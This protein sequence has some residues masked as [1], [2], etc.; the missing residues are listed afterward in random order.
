[1]SRRVSTE[2]TQ[3][4]AETSE[5]VRPPDTLS[6]R[7]TADALGSSTTKLRKLI[8]QG[9]LPEAEKVKT[10]EGRVWAVPV[11]AIPG[12]A[13]RLGMVVS[14][15]EAIDVREPETAV[16]T[17]QE[18]L[19]AAPEEIADAPDEIA[20]APELDIADAPQEIA[21]APE[22]I[23]VAVAA[24]QPERHGQT[25]S[26]AA[27]EAAGT[28]V[29]ITSDIDIAESNDLTLAE[30][31]DTALLER[32][33]GAKEAETTALV[34]AERHRTEYESLAARQLDVERRYAEEIDRAANLAQQLRDE[35]V[36]RAVADTRVKELRD[37]L[38][39]EIT[40]TE[41]ERYE[42]RQ[43]VV[44]ETQAA[45]EAARTRAAMGWWSRRRLRASG[46][47]EVDS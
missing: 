42:R 40:Y 15:A 1:M 33:L 29:E 41:A 5:P 47:P 38:Q 18:T 36:A 39:R 17:P 8:R 19:A 13:E 28:D 24:I 30:V 32:L 34:K 27:I 35:A 7:E 26:S 31:L 2:E 43:A 21:V 20:V 23:A 6:L 10:F 37:Q 22:E 25:A 16:P 11:T 46:V 3:P 45:A 4:E 14:V 12:I 9:R 44:R